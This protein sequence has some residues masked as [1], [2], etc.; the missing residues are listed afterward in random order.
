MTEQRAL[1]KSQVELVWKDSAVFY[2]FLTGKT[3]TDYQ[4]NFMR[5]TSTRISFRSGRR[6]GKTEVVAAKA[7]YF[8]ITYPNQEIL[9]LGPFQEHAQILIERVFDF[10]ANNAFIQNLVGHQ[11][12]TTIF[13][14][15]NNSRILARTIGRTGLGIR[16]RSP[17][18][19]FIDEAAYIPEAA[20]TA[21]EMCLATV[22]TRYLIYTS[23][24]F[25]KR[26]RFYLS[27]SDPSSPFS[28]YYINAED[29][30]IVNKTFLIEQKNILTELE[31]KQ[32]VQGEFIEEADVFITRELFLSCCEDIPDKLQPDIDK[33]YYLGVD[34][35]RYGTDET[36]FTVGEV[37][38]EG[39][40]SIIHLEATSKKE[41]TDTAGRV[42]NLHKQFN[43]KKIFVD[44]TGLGAGAVDMLHEQDIPVV[45]ITF[46]LKDKADMYRNFKWCFEK[47]LI[48]LP[49]NI[50]LI[51][52]TTNLIYEYSSTG[53]LRIHHPEESRAHD[54]YPDACALVCLSIFRQNE[55][56]VIDLELIE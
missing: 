54:D 37:T 35:A 28:T 15:H 53:I 36:V 38:A 44:E 46:T 40:L 12:Q 14:K 17:T 47:K 32:E 39:E 34:I 43:F 6:C 9:L 16:G 21:V 52:Q 1:S 29:S 5:D 11:T 24:P 23:T 42:I 18:V 30:P 10:V 27:C 8:A 22:G 19:I 2:K 3:P 26:G 45:P 56:T 55:N 33:D 48:K 13:F 31:Y 4:A 20:F 51:N 49:P 41:L 7:L 25:G 50:K